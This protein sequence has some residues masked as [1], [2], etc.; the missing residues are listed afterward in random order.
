MCLKFLMIKKQLLLISSLFVLI[1]IGS[2]GNDE[3]IFEPAGT[4]QFYISNQT[5]GALQISFITSATLGSME[6]DTIATF[7]QG[8]SRKIFEYGDFGVN[9]RPSDSFSELVFI[10]DNNL[11]KPYEISTIKNEEWEI[12]TTDFDGTG[13]GLTVYQLNIVDANF[14]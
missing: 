14:D 8:D 6:I 2:C 10:K 7:Q 12:I 3:V 4:A 11:E 9:P 13:F 5:T 1:L